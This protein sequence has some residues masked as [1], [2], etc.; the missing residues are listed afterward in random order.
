[1]V[2]GVAGVASQAIG[3]LTLPIFARTF[4]P[5]QYGI[6]EIATVGY[7]ALLI[8]ADSGL[9]AAAQRS[10]YD[11]TGAQEEEQRKALLTGLATSLGLATLAAGVLLILAGPISH[12]VFGTARY[13]TIVRI[14]A[15]TLPL[16]T[17]ATFCREIMRMKLRP[18]LYTVSA[19]LNSAGAA[20]L[21]IGAVLLLD[22]G[23]KGILWATLIGTAAAALYGL[24]I[25]RPHL[26]RRFSRVELR[27]MLAYGLPLLPAAGALWGLNF[28]D[29]VILV[30]SA[31]LAEAGLYALAIKFAQGMNVI[32]RGFQLAFPP[33]AYSIDDDEEARRAYSL[34]VTWFAA[35]CAFGVWIFNHEAPRIAERL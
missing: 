6:L 16:G 10:Y 26:A 3:V 22:A 4:A 1:M 31:G 18:W 2:Y 17:L 27:K 5:T 14:V 8:I 9:A 34:V 28:I 24:V 15:M 33:L 35:V 13:A 23:V 12:L 25:D 29:R 21:A 19:L 32:A 20:I 11:Y 7:S 30:R